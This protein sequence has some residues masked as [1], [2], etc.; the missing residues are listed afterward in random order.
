MTGR[1][2]RARHATTLP[3][4]SSRRPREPRVDAILRPADAPPVRSYAPLLLLVV[5]CRTTP[6]PP[7][8][9]HAPRPFTAEQIRDATKAGAVWTYEVRQLRKPVVHQVTTVTAA[10]AEGATFQQVTYNQGG[11]AIG[12][13]AVSTATW[14]ELVAHA[15]FPAAA[16]TV[17]DTTVETPAGAFEA[18]LYEVAA[19]EKKQTKRFYFAKKRPGAP[20]LFEQ[21]DA[22]ETVFRMALLG[23]EEVLPNRASGSD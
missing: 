4:L 9:D 19:P 20:V 1:E 16:T 11:E 7:A 6:T 10:G 18:W 21:Q 13:P 3:Q 2:V 5:A 14:A 12:D 8:S 22:G 15:T 23:D 17:S